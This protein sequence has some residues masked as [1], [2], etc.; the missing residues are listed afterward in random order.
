VAKPLDEAERLVEIGGPLELELVDRHPGAC[1]A[2]SSVLALCHDEPPASWWYESEYAEAVMSFLPFWSCSVSSYQVNQKHYAYGPLPVE[3][4]GWLAND[5][6]T[7][8]E[9]HIGQRNLI[10]IAY[11]EENQ[12]VILVS[13]ECVT[14]NQIRLVDIRAV[15]MEEPV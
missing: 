3:R 14:L 8:M 10:C 13:L 2:H 4:E 15:T 12:R 6:Y 5:N 7:N 11:E 1:R 9:F